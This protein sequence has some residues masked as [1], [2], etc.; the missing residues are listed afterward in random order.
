MN[1]LVKIEDGK[2]EVVKEVIERIKASEK[3]KLEIELMQKEFKRELKEAMEKCG[4]NK[5]VTDELCATIREAST[6]TT[7]NSKKL[8]EELPEIYEQYS[9]TSNV[10]SSIILTI[11]E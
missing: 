1:E 4:I 6:R 7:L 10:A 8:K 9:K 2:I 11:G 3:M 5:W